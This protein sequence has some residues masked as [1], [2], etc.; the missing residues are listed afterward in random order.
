MRLPSLSG[1]LLA[2]ALALSACGGGGAATTSTQP[3]ANTGSGQGFQSAAT[4][5]PA[6]TEKAAATEKP[7]ATATPKPSPTPVP[8]NAAEV[9]SQALKKVEQ[10]KTY[11]MAMTATLEGDLGAGAPAGIDPNKPFEFMG[12][13]GTVDGKNSAFAM[14]GMVATMMGVEADK[15]IEFISVDGETYVH[16]PLELLGAKEDKWYKLPAGENPTESMNSNSMVKSMAGDDLEKFKFAE[17]GK[18][19][20]DGQ[21]CTVYDGDKE[22][23]IA[24]MKEGKEGSSGLPSASSFG[25][26]KDALMQFAVCEDGYVHRM[27]MSFTGQPE[28]QDKPATMVMTMNLS[29]FGKPGKIEAPANAEEVQ[30]PGS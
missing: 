19:K 15:G 30:K 12:L 28:N 22:A 10:S 21:S 7:A 3:P 16:G 11:A 26:L 23:T 25:E 17:S 6:A 29:D 18:E 5:K 9:I 4:A 13:E 27:V 20:L 2:G 24:A 8:A 1:I 14:K